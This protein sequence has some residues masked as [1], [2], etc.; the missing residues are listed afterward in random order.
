MAHVTYLS[1]L[2]VHSRENAKWNKNQ[3]QVSFNASL[4]AVSVDGSLHSQVICAEL[5]N[6]IIFCSRLI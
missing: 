4:P 6:E 5:S 2:E 3:H 1:F